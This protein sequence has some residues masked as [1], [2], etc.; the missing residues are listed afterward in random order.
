M[1]PQRTLTLGVFRRLYNQSEGLSDDSPRALELHNRRR[2]A[3]HEVFD[4][5]TSLTVIDWGQTDDTNSH[6]VVELLV[7]VAAYAVCSYTIV[8]RLTFLGEKPV[9]AAVGHATSEAV[10]AVV[11]WLRPKQ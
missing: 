6:E 4:A 7:G 8:P 10:K 3:L 2:D 11:S 9:E 5:S 1:E